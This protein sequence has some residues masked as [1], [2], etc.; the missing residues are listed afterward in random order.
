MNF[1]YSIFRSLL[2]LSSLL[3]VEGWAQSRNLD[4]LREKEMLNARLREEDE[5]ARKQVEKSLETAG[6][7]TRPKYSSAVPK[8]YLSEKNLPASEKKLLAP[9]LQLTQKFAT[10]LRQPETGLAKILNFN[11]TKALVNDVKSPS[12]YP[13]IPGGGTFYSFTKR[14]HIADE[15]AQLRLRNGVFQPAYSE[16]KRT[17]VTESGG[18]QQNFNYTSGY[19]WALLTELGNV[20]LD[21]VTLEN[22]VIQ[23]LAN[24][25]PPM[26]Y[27]DFN[28]QLQLND[29]GIIADN[30]IYKSSVPARLNTT[31][32]MRSLNYKRADE[33]I[34]FQV[35]HADSEG[36]VHLLWKQI[37]RF[38]APELKGKPQ[39]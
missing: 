33:V 23:F 20:S 32:V 19:G 37:A 21:T 25:Q 28:H 27:Q 38:S 16:M 10:F 11:E 22:P 6:K 29:A 35:I 2:I 31:Y 7:D 18:I 36:N 8:L 14:H 1:T 3:L 34:A 24:F 4:Q 13:Q 17:T 15:W 26:Q 5:K 30:R 12:A 39:K 9:D